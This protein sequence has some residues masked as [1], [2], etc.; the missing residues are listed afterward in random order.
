AIPRRPER[1][2][3]VETRPHERRL[4]GIEPG[5]VIG[6]SS[7]LAGVIAVPLDCEGELVCELRPRDARAFERDDGHPEHAPLPWLLEHEL[8]VRAREWRSACKRAI[9]VGELCFDRAHATAP[10]GSSA[11]PVPII[12]SRVTSPASRSS[13]QP[14]VPA[15]RS[16]RTR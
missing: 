9:D 4:E 12:E 14:S 5:A 16:G 6:G 11:R 15:G 3:E 7:G 2:A 13:D 8:T 1:L 10:S